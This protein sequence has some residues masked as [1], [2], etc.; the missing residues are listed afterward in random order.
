MKK[1]LCKIPLSYVNTIND[2]KFDYKKGY[3]LDIN[4]TTISNCNIEINK[5]DF[6]AKEMVSI[7]ISS[8]KD[9]LYLEVDALYAD[10][11]SF[12]A[13]MLLELLEKI[14]PPLTYNLHNFNDNKHTVQYKLTY[15]F[16]EIEIKQFNYD[17]YDDYLLENRTENIYKD[18]LQ[19]EDAVSIEVVQSV[20][21]DNYNMIFNSYTKSPL[22]K[23]IIDSYIRA[24]GDTDY[25]S[26]YFNLF[27]IIEAMETHYKKDVD[28]KILSGNEIENLLSY[29]KKAKLD[30]IEDKNNEQIIRRIEDTLNRITTNPRGKKLLTILNEFLKIE[31]IFVIG[32]KIEVN[33]SFVSEII[34]QRNTLFHAKKFDDKDLE[35]LKTLVHYLSILCEQIINKLISEN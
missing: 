5:M 35:K 29:I 12:A 34:K 2:N 8:N 10:N 4:H 19:M 15:D 22:L 6:A 33:S 23:Q 18:F 21:L 3:K 28:E 24:M 25:L 17:K 1:Y 20:K 14:L 27:I 32:N 7:T 16:S 31:Y 11:K 26:K 13:S 9:I 30:F